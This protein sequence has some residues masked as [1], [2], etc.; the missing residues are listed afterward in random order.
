MSYYDIEWAGCVWR[1]WVKVNDCELYR[2]CGWVL[3][4]D[5]AGGM[6]VFG[7]WRAAVNHAYQWTLREKSGV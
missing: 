3:V 2:G 4:V 7:N 5:K 1:F 6:R